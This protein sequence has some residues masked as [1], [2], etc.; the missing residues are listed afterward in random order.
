MSFVVREEPVTV[1]ATTK[2]NRFILT[3]LLFGARTYRTVRYYIHQE[4]GVERG[5]WSCTSKLL[6]R[7]L[8]IP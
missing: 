1:C 4:S 6:F 7:S 2:D 3:L 5:I 8:G